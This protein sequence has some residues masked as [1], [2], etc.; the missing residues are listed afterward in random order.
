MSVNPVDHGLPR[1]Q[2]LFYLESQIADRKYSCVVVDAGAASMCLEK[3]RRTVLAALACDDN[4]GS[5]S[6]KVYLASHSDCTFVI[7]K[8]LLLTG[9]TALLVLSIQQASC[10][11]VIGNR[12]WYNVFES[13][14]IVLTCCSG[15]DVACVSGL[16]NDT[17]AYLLEFR[18]VHRS[19]FSHD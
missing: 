4:S 11:E 6:A 15:Q 12:T 18:S 16:A 3:H 10:S 8:N 9:Y 7:L 2:Q 17:S 19:V 13:E 14:A 1:Q 5:P